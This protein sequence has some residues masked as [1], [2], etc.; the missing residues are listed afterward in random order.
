M[1]LNAQFQSVFTVD[2]NSVPVSMSEPSFP[3]IHDLVIDPIGVA[4]LLGNINPKKAC[5]PDGIPCIVLKELAL[6]LAPVLTA[7]FEQSIV[8]GSLPEDWLKAY[9]N[10]IFKKGNQNMAENYRPVSLTCV[11]SKLLEH[12]ICTHIWE[13]LDQHN[14]IT[15]KQHGFRRRH[16]C[17]SQLIIT[18]Q[19]LFQLRDS[20]VQVD[21]AILDFSKAFDTVPHDKLLFKLDHYGIKG[22]ILTWISAFLKH[23]DQCVVVDGVHSDWVHVDSGVPQGTVLGPLLFLLHINDLPSRVTSRVRLFAD[24]CLVY[25]PIRCA[26]DQLEMQRD[27]DSLREWSDQWGMRFNPA[28]CNILRFHRSKTPLE[29]FYTLCDQVLAQVDDAKYLGVNIS[30][31]LE[32]SSHI[33]AVTSKSNQ[34]L[35]FIRRNLNECPKELR[36]TAYF[37]LVRSTLEYACTVWDPH[38]VKDINS[39]EKVQRLAA[40]VVVHDFS[41]YT[42]VTAIMEELGWESLADR[43][44][45]MRLCLM[46]KIVHGLVNIPTADIL[47]PTD[48]RTRQSHPYCYRHL[49][50]H[51]NSYKFSYFPHTIPEWDSLH[52]DIVS[53]PTLPTFKSR[54]KTSHC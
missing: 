39:L 31:N 10:P 24:D 29:R 1:V 32:W 42:S 49:A 18:T 4:K 54:L 50:T 21:M 14:I 45:D 43:R 37:S 15:D 22:P 41:S 30:H 7:L 28:K 5:G 12:I 9:I 35:G 8:S 6:E 51:T 52:T 44:R 27:L 36:Q 3:A 16:S 11:C 33:D 13:H 48:S 26:N 17:E 53:S 46:Y 2:D 19:D 38:L 23:R 34:S 20:N 40:R 25:R 47:T